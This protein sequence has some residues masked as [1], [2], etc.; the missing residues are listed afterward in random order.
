MYGLQSKEMGFVQL[1]RHQILKDRDHVVAIKSSQ[2]QY[3]ER[4]IYES[5]LSAHVHYV[6]CEGKKVPEDM[7]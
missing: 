4:L 1:H 2:A 3:R 7:N 6:A 5:C